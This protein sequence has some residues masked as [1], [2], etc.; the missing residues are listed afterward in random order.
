ME[1]INKEWL[2]LAKKRVAK[3]VMAVTKT[4]AINA[5]ID[6]VTAYKQAVEAKVKTNIAFYEKMADND[7]VSTLNVLLTD[8]NNLTPTSND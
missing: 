8:L 1:T 4:E 7:A 2:E 3:E 5:Q 6:L